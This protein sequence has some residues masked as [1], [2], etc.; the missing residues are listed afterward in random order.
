MKLKIKLTE[1]QTSVLNEMMTE[2]KTL[3]EEYV[4]LQNKNFPDD[5]IEPYTD[6]DIIYGALHEAKKSIEESIL[7]QSKI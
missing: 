7:I 2:L 4:I 3:F 5:K 6:Y 1:P